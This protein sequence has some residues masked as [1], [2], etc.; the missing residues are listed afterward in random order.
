VHEVLDDAGLAASVSVGTDVEAAFH[1]AFD[2][3][4]GILLIAGTGSISLARDPKGTV[5]RVGGWGRHLG[6]EGSGYAI[7]VEEL[8]RLTWAEDGRAESTLMRSGLL[9]RC[10]VETVQDLIA[11]VGAASKAD[12][13]ALTP[14]VADAANAGD[15]AATEI[16]EDAV[17]SLVGHVAAALES[18]GEWSDPAPLVLWGGL[19]AEGGSLRERVIAALSGIDVS[20]SFRELDPTMGAAKLALAELGPEDVTPRTSDSEH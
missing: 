11:W 19:L 13:A 18:T 3:G 1:A 12:L 8:K 5:R 9:V 20:L 16:V 2:E 7:G 14:I 15:V 6:D 17:R 10:D 4:P